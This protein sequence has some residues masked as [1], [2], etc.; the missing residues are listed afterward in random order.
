MTQFIQNVSLQ[1]IKDGR[2]FDAGANSM[3]IQITDPAGT[4]P[5][6]YHK[7]KETYRFEFLDLDN[8]QDELFGEGC[9]KDEQAAAIVRLLKHARE[10]KMQVIV[11][12]HA[13]LCRS[14]AVAEV[15]I[16]M[17]FTDTEAVRL[18]NT[19]VKQK[20]MRELG[21]TYDAK[22]KR[23]DLARRCRTVRVWF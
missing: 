11:H 12:C 20:L 6:P 13:G 19:L 23:D 1:A 16:M 10:D 8:E 22:M 7:F 21:L 9:I 18:P 3:L 4:F 15:G 5:K 14:G 2:H 17:G